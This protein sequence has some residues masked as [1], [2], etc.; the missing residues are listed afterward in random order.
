MKRFLFVFVF[1]CVSWVWLFGIMGSI[2]LCLFY[3][4]GGY[5]LLLLLLLLLPPLYRWPPFLSTPL[6]LLLVLV[7]PHLPFRSHISVPYPVDSP[8]YLPYPPT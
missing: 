6:L 7:S 8:T 1:W 3:V 2:L 5:L 4:F